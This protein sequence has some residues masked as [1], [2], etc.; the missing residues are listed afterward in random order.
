[1]KYAFVTNKIVIGGV[2]RSLINLLNTDFFQQQDVDLYLFDI[3]GEWTNQIPKNVN[4]I[5][6]KASDNYLSIIHPLNSIKNIYAYCRMRISKNIQTN[7]FYNCKLL[8]RYDKEYDVAI[9]YH[10]P[11]SITTFFTLYNLNSK[12]RE[13]YI[14]GDV[15]SSKCNTDFMYNHYKKFDTIKCV[16][17]DSFNIFLKAF[18]TL[19]DI[20]TVEYNIIDSDKIIQLSKEKCTIFCDNYSFS[21]LTVAR[22]S[23]EKGI[24]LAIET[25]HQLKNHN[26]DIKWYVCGE[27]PERK[28]LEDKIKEYNLQDDFILLGSSENPYKYIK[29]CNLYVQPSRHE[30]YCLTLA[31]ALL[32]KNYAICTEFTGAFEQIQNGI[33]GEIVKFDSSSLYKKILEYVDINNVHN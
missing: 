1:M 26:L 23:K 25:M 10:S 30:G 28:F 12:R 11:R 22:L 20:T 32:I 33:N 3:R 29:N 15:I 8:H 13:L 31:E 27:G 5:E 19:Y 24:D 17:K 6:I 4:I 14:H 16:S 18:P 21:I 2:E 7:R 9:S